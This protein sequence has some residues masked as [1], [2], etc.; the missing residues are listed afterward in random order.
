MA[1]AATNGTIKVRAVDKAAIRGIIKAKAVAKVE[2][3][4]IAKAAVAAAAVFKTA[5]IITAVIN[6]IVI[7]NATA[8]VVAAAA[9]ATKV[10][11]VAVVAAETIKTAPINRAAKVS[12]IAR[13]SAAATKP[14]L[15]K[16][17][18]NSTMVGSKSRRKASDSSVPP[19]A[20][21]PQNPPTFS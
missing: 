4:A 3:R 20:I 17:N 10:V 2:I 5:N 16:S 6:I 8:V 13:I 15:P 21:S 12:T 11:A 18:S 7:S 14:P 19:K 1:K 9:A